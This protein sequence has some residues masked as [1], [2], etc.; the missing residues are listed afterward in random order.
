[1][2]IGSVKRM[3]LGQFLGHKTRAGGTKSFLAN[4]HAKKNG[5]P[6]PKGLVCEIDVLL[7]AAAGISAVWQHPFRRLVT[8]EKNEGG[9]Q[10]TKTE[11]WGDSIN[12]LEDEEVLKRQFFYDDEGK[13]E[14]P[15]EVCPMC[16]MLETIA[17]MIDA[18]QLDWCAPVFKFEAV[19]METQY[20]Y[21]GGLTGLFRSKDL[22][23]E[24][25]EQMFH[26][27]KV[28]PRNAY[29]QD[30]TAGCKYV[31]CVADVSALQKG[32]QITTES[33]SLGQKVQDMIDK[34]MRGGGVTGNPFKHPYVIR[35]ENYPDCD[36]PKEKYQAFPIRTTPITPEMRQLVDSPPP[37]ALSKALGYPNMTTLRAT[38]ERQCLVPLPWDEIFAPVLEHCDEHGNVVVEGEEAE[39]EEEGEP[40][41]T[42]PVQGGLVDSN[43]SAAPCDSCR[44]LFPVDMAKCPHCGKEYDLVDADEPA[45]AAQLQLAPT[46]LQQVIAPSAPAQV[47]NTGPGTPLPAPKIPQA[48]GKGRK[49]RGGSGGAPF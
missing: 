22:T 34:E 13:R 32:I 33:Q 29:Q 39:G 17:L 25:K 5:K 46:P 36:D 40:A 19:G 12:C 44:Q 14:V 47:T 10:V 24:D 4:W 7:N 49:K 43:V 11:V 31:F 37:E 26:A 15:P 41:P 45:A 35:W 23:A 48:P 38:L 8:M 6:S 21:A 27:T 9:V 2:S 16:R 42:G 18:G 30:A 28:T 1:M 3:S 20:L